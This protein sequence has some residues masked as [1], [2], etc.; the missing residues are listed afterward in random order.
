MEPIYSK[1]FEIT[2]AA[3]D[4]FDRLKASHLLRFL[5]EVAG[6]HS[7]LL[8]TDRGYLME[9]GLFWAVI[10][11][12]VQITRLP[13]AGEHIRIET[14]PMPTTRTAYPR[15]TIGY[16]E[17]GNEIFRCISLWVLMDEKSR[18]MVLPG[19][20]GVEVAGHLRGCEL[21]TPGSMVPREMAECCRRTV[22]YTDLDVNGHMNNCRYLDLIDDLLPSAFHEHHQMREFSLCYL[23]E[24][25][26]GETLDLHW[27]LSDGPVLS[28]EA[29]RADHAESGGHSRVF[30]AKIQLQNGV[31]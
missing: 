3:T 19:K 7:A 17:G 13:H 20:S 12:R 22:R 4:R 9:R 18:A 2:P 29:V 1:T 26:E 23:S 16:D 10:R 28:V 24:I 11:H 14:W 31:L 6:D 21:A 8:G 27:E 25:R 5:Q 30:S 15:S